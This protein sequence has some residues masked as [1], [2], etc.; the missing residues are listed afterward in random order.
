MVNTYML[1]DDAV[2]WLKR[3]ANTTHTQYLYVYMPAEIDFFNF[4]FFV[5]PKTLL[6][7]V[8]E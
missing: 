7:A 6:S 4:F 8:R 3:H 5:V 1:F 2:E